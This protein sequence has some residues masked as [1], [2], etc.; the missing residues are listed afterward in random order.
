MSVSEKKNL[1]IRVTVAVVG[2]PLLLSL[3]IIGR[4]PFLILVAAASFLGMLEFSKIARGNQVQIPSLLL[5]LMTIA[6][7][8]LLYFEQ[9]RLLPLLY[10]I[11]FF[12][13]TVWSLKLPAD[14]SAKFLGFSFLGLIYVSLFFFWILIRQ[15]P[16]TSG[17]DYTLGGQWMVSL[18]LTV[19]S[20]DTTAYFGGK[21]LGR[22]KLAPTIS[23]LL[24]RSRGSN[25]RAR[26]SNS[27]D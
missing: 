23:P 12:M 18:F 1:L 7:L 27:S 14:Q 26:R 20:C 25:S 4:I 15:L 19:W 22:H 11:V 6:A 2:I 10:I 17:L 3:S 9:T 16:L 8:S 21:G 13:L 5:G 24:V